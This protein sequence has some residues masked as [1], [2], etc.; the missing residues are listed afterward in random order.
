[1][2]MQAGLGWKEHHIPSE[3][4][5]ESMMTE[6]AKQTMVWT[7]LAFDKDGKQAGVLHLPYSVTRS[8]YGMIDIPVAVIKN[9]DRPSV[10]LMAGNHG[11]EYEGQ[12]RFIARRASRT[13]GANPRKAQ[14]TIFMRTGSGTA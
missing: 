9:G 8:A 11:D 10:L 7:E 1:M 2:G 6:A 14:Q 3:G 13:C 5:S 4:R 12:Q